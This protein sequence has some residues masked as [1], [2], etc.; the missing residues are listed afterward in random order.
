MFMLRRGLPVNDVCYFIGEDVPKM[1]GARIP[2]LPD[3]YSFDYIN[4]EVIINRLSVKNGKLVLPDGMSYELMVLPPLDNMRPEVLS[5][6]RDLVSQGASVYGPPPEKSPGLQN[7]PQADK[8]IVALASELWGDTEGSGS[9]KG[10]SLNGNVFNGIDLQSAL[11]KLEVLPDVSFKGA[12]PVLWIHRQ[13]GDIDIYFLTNQSDTVANFSAAFRT[14]GKQPELWDAVNGRI[15][16]LHAFTSDT[17][18][19]SVPLKLEA[20]ESAFI[21][22]RKKGVTASG[23]AEINFPEPELVANINTPWEVSFDNAMRGPAEVLK[24]TLPGDWSQSTDERVK[25]YSGTAV[26]R[27]SFRSGTPEPGETICLNLG[28]VGVMA[29]VRING[30]LAGGVWSSPWRVDITKLIRN[31]GNEVEISVVNNWVNRLIGDSR[32]PEKERK[33]WINVNEIRSGDALQPS[34]LLGEVTVTRV[35]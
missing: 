31:G 28:R 15:R 13:L 4:A 3:G 5:R 9:E 17:R 34:G 19:T 10:K 22:F 35:R 33:T 14:V 25:Y 8:D 18:T 7:F 1:T 6:I 32:L 30:Q 11:N 26:Y 2:E 20:S 21:V 16:D 27:N 29:E 12:V 24:L 23:T